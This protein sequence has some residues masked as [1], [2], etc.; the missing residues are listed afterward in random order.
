M[1]FVNSIMKSAKVCAFFL[2]EGGWYIPVRQT[3][4]IVLCMSMLIDFWVTFLNMQREARIVEDADADTMPAIPGH[5]MYGV[6]LRSDV[7]SGDHVVTSQ[8]PLRKCQHIHIIVHNK[9]N[10]GL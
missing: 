1:A 7:T 9:F 2:L 4:D 5:T 10:D 3:E 8:P 6:T